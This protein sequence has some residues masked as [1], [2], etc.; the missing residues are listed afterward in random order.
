MLWCLYLCTHFAL[1]ARMQ[2]DCPCLET[3]HHATYP[4]ANCTKHV[5]PDN[6]TT[7]QRQDIHNRYRHT[8]HTHTCTTRRTAQ[9]KPPSCICHN[10]DPCG[11]TPRGKPPCKGQQNATQTHTSSRQSKTRQRARPKSSH[12]H[13]ILYCKHKTLCTLTEGQFTLE[14]TDPD[15]LSTSTYPSAQR[16]RNPTRPQHFSQHRVAY[17]CTVSRALHTYTPL[18]MTAKVH[19]RRTNGQVV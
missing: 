9:H 19:A 17:T 10:T 5:S 3:V 4:A 13:F 16:S 2:E 8:Q 11:H 18:S 6:N 15:R 12:T 14:C 1:P 7:D